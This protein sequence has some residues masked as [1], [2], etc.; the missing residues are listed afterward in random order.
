MAKYLCQCFKGNGLLSRNEM[1]WQDP[2]GHTDNQK[3]IKSLKMK[4]Q[5]I[6]QATLIERRRAQ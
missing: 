3:D 5:N 2:Q 1:D 4:T 6:H